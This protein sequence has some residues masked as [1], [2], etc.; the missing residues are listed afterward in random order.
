MAA[1][2]VG[3]DLENLPPH[4]LT[5]AQ[6]GE[7]DRL[8]IAAGTPGRI[9]MARA[10]AAVAQAALRLI[11]RPGRVAVLC[12]PGNNG[13]DGFVAAR[14]LR[15]AGWAVDLALLG[16][17]R[18]LR[19]DAVSAAAGW[20]A[21]PLS[22]DALSLEGCDLV[23]DALFGAGLARPLEG[24]ALAL[25]A[26]ANAW[27]RASGRPILAV[28]IASGIDGDS[29]SL[30]GG[31][32][33]AAAT[34]TF[35]RL[36]PGHLLLPGRSQCGRV[37][38]AQIGISDEALAAIGPR[39]FAN[40]PALWRRLLRKP[41]VAG[42]KYTRG[43]AVVVSGGALHTGAAR[44]AA[45]GA[46]RAGAGLVTIASP[47]D[48]LPVHAAH[49]TA[50]MLVCAEDAAALRALLADARKNAIVLGPALGVGARARGMV[51]AALGAGEGRAVVLDADALTSF[52]GD[53]AGLASLVAASAGPVVLTPHE[54]EFARLFGDFPAQIS[55]LERTRR[56]AE[57]SGAIV[58]L[59]GADTV[60]AH[61]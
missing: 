61:P 17:S 47:A 26:R 51:E 45:R 57:L 53:L 32:I 5:S 8:T 44:L 22:P 41:S 55:K 43:H 2:D 36:K 28:D 38:L 15:E 49:L 7:A 42:Y 58:V 14:L 19:G 52:S 54:G 16:A 48:A 6:M 18:D 46:L 3:M 30:R 23:I 9:L 35:F 27:S 33:K 10:G 50:I 21:P 25:V 29:G 59:K 56:A 37:E 34:V 1:H 24:A 31:A 13:G 11:G 60:I 4:L 20:S 12:G 39:A 40:G